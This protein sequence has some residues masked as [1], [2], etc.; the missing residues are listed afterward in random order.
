[1]GYSDPNVL[2]RIGTKEKPGLL[3]ALVWNG[4]RFIA[5]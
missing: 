2:N 1:M 5:A 3:R 4:L